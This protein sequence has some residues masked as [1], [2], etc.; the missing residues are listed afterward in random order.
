MNEHVRADEAARALDEIQRRQEQVINLATIPTWYWWVIA[1]L[2]VGLSASVDSHQRLTI[3]IGVT[4]FVLGV[5]IS[6]GRVVMNGL[7]AQLHN[8]FLGPAGV[9]S[10]LGFVA[11]V[12]AVTL[13][14]AFGLRAAHVSYPGT[15]GTA[16]GA[17]ILAV[18]G[19]ILM[20]RLRR[21]MLNN[22][23]GIR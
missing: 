22:R 4:V 3:G 20:R 6:T 10:I 14:T 8:D 15:I 13:P 1:V 16:A 12:L 17:V 9:L 5:L 19:P 2:M 21:L 23:S 11:L 7:R 18:G